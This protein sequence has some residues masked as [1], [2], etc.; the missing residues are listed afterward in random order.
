MDTTDPEI[1]FDDNG[2]CNHCTRYCELIEK[3]V[4]TGE[5]G[6]RRL[7]AIVDKIK[8]QGKNK[9]YDCILGL[10]GGVDSTY[11]AYLTKQLGLRPY[12]ITLDNG[13]DTEVTKRN[14]QR[15]VDYLNAELHV[16]SIDPEEFRDLQ[17]AYLKSGVL[18]IEVLT[19]H[20]ILAL[21]YR[22]AAKLEI[23]YVLSGQNIVTEG[24]L[25][26]SWGYDNRDLVNIR[27]I[28][29]K[30]GSGRKLKTF[31]QIS[32]AHFIYYYFFK[33]IEF[34][35]LLNYVSYMKKD[36]K[37]LFTREFNYEDY[38]AKHCES[39]FTK[40]YQ[41]YMLPRRAHVDKRRAHLSCMVCSGQMTREEALKELEKPPYT[42]EELEEDKKF[43][44]TRLGLTEEQ[45]ES[46]ISQPIRSNFEYKTDKRT[47]Q[48][49][50]FPRRQ[51]RTIRNLG[52][53]ITKGVT[54]KN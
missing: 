31:P 19:D 33:E 28:Y 52:I 34:V 24:I 49:L 9:D 3:I 47:M 41:F 5:D 12:L 27:D 35:H 40:F 8:K 43:V 45:F 38:G 13:Y 53:K 50:M 14:V 7:R 22:T 51:W 32:V 36:A 18:N 11:V 17:L 21:L 16:H 10:S 23:K 26:T 39:V 1:Q 25:P 20:A 29:K 54:V 37:A 2:V 6:E 15:I 46:L 42:K 44:L 4:F 48:I 30:H